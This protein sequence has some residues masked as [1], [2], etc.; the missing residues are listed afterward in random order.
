MKRRRRKRRR[1][2]NLFKFL[3]LATPEGTVNPWNSQIYESVGFSFGLRQ[4]DLR[5]FYL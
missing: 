5:F 3:G 2:K 4:F 1:K